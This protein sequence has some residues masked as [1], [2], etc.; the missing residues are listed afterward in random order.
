VSEP[1]QEKMK[2]GDQLKIAITGANGNLGRKLISAFLKA[3]EIAAIRALDRDTAGLAALGNP[4]L[5]PVTV[6]L[7][8]PT[9][10]DAFARLD[11]VVHLAAQNPYPDATWEDASASFDMT[12][13]VVEASARAGLRRFVFASSNHVMGGYKDTPVAQSAGALSTDL[14]PL[15]GT[16]VKTP[17]G[18]IDSTAYAAAKLMGERLVAARAATGAFSGVSLRIGWCQPGENRPETLSAAGT[19]KSGPVED[20]P[21]RKPDL[22]WFKAMRLSNGDLVR[23]VSAVLHADASKWPARAVVVNAVS[24]NRPSPWDLSAGRN[25]LGYHPLDDVWTYAQPL[26]SP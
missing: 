4:R 14:P 1:L 21:E 15:V 3:P 19:P 26:P 8:D 13:R 16:R 10:D 24:A 23:C 22:R 5:V 2:P 11:A 18:L 9:L 25:L 17:E 20:D 6:D 7:R 12:A